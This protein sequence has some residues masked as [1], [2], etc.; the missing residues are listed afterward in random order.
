MIDIQKKLV[1]T[2]LLENGR[3]QRTVLKHFI[4]DLNPRDFEEHVS[5]LPLLRYSKEHQLVV[6][7]LI[8]CIHAEQVIT[9]TSPLFSSYT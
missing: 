2:F 7:G 5:T 8:H 1:L 6:G 3:K 4:E 9:K